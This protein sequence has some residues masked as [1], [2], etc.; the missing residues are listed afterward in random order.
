M[1]WT[2]IHQT[3]KLPFS[4]P[5]SSDDDINLSYMI[6]I[7]EVSMKQAYGIVQSILSMHDWNL[8]MSFE[9][10]TEEVETKQCKNKEWPWYLFP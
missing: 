2:E 9:F 5:K 10:E 7:C 4:A 8:K 6:C 1:I 3:L